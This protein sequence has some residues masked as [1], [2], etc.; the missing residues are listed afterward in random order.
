MDNYYHVIKGC[1]NAIFGRLLGSFFR[2]D[3]G[4]W[5]TKFRNVMHQAIDKLI[6]TQ[7]INKGYPQ[8]NQ[9]GLRFLCNSMRLVQPPFGIARLFLPFHCLGIVYCLFGHQLRQLIVM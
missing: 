7:Q 3:T 1:G 6:N 9:F 5:S 2:F 4:V 8:A